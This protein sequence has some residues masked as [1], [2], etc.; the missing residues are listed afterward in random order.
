MR[1]LRNTFFIFLLILLFNAS[2]SNANAAKNFSYY[3]KLVISDGISWY[4]DKNSASIESL[5]INETGLHEKILSSNFH[6]SVGASTYGTLL[7]FLTGLNKIDKLDK[8]EIITSNMSKNTNS[9]YSPQNPLI[10]GH[11][12]VNII[13]QPKAGKTKAYYIKFLYFS[14]TKKLKQMASENGFPNVDSMND[15]TFLIAL[16]EQ[17]SENYPDNFHQLEESTIKALLSSSINGI[18]F[19]NYLKRHK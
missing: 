10:S 2:I 18:Q 4:Q 9:P 15:K 7:D 5:R 12:L 13:H 1:G 8:I 6:T 16:E 11:C 14:D 19:L 17:A 3:D